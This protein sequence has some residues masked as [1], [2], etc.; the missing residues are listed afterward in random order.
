MSLRWSVALVVALLFVPSARSS[1]AAEP[2]ELTVVSFNVLVD[3]SREEGVPAW[4]DRKDLCLEALKK[5]DPDLIGFQETSP[6]QV[7]FF[8]EGLP[9]YKSHAYKGYP[10]ALLFYRESAFE[11]LEQ[12]HW[13]LSPT[14]EKVTTGFGNTLPRLVVWVKLKHKAS[15]RELLFFNTHF[16]NSMPSQIKMAALCQEQFKR[17]YDLKLPMI[18]TGDFNTDQKRGDYP[19]LTSNDW[20]DAYLASDKASADGRDDNVGTHERG[21]RIDHIFYHGEGMKAVSWQRIE[22]P[23]PDR[24]LSDHWAITAK[25]AIP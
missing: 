8:Q 7:K 19:T 6:L 4:K 11:E 23:D 10:D 22:S 16:D 13:W 9:G 21:T 25:I 18:F 12:G 14:P 24:R 17:F 15:G 5:V 2:L 3:F 1:R 20:H